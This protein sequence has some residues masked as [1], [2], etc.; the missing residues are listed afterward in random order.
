MDGLD[1]DGSGAETLGTPRVLL[2]CCRFHG[3][4]RSEAGNAQ[5]AKAAIYERLQA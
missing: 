2:G 3:K 1:A 4:V 5:E